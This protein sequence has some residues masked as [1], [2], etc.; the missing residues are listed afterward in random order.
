[1]SLSV[2]PPTYVV[3]AYMNGREPDG[4][5]SLIPKMAQANDEQLNTEEGGRRICDGNRA[6]YRRR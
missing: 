6:T 1:M 4:R 3:D 2:L 5:L